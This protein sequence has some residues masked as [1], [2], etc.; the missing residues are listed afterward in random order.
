[1]NKEEIKK[2]IEI[3]KQPITVNCIDYHY[4]TQDQYDNLMSVYDNALWLS[5]IYDQILKEN[6]QLKEKC[7]K[8][9]FAIKE[10]CDLRLEVLNLKTTLEEI[11]DKAKVR[12]SRLENEPDYCKWFLEGYDRAITVNRLSNSGVAM[13]WVKSTM[14]KDC[15][16][17]LQIIDKGLGE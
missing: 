7:E 8:Q 15:K 2:A 11:I 13:E 10:N 5:N 17:L 16:D 4:F 9:A 6:Q 14:I 3:L 12:L 1:M